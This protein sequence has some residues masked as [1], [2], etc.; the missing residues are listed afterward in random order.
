MQAA[1]LSCQFYRENQ[2]RMLIR[3]GN[4]KPECCV[5][6]PAEDILG[7]T[8]GVGQAEQA[9]LH[10]DGAGRYPAG[11]LTL[12]P[13]LLLQL[14]NL[15]VRVQPSMHLCRQPLSCGALWVFHQ[16]G[17]L[18]TKALL[19]FNQ[20]LVGSDASSDS[21]QLQLEAQVNMLSKEAVCRM[22]GWHL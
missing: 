21:Q 11:S 22:T 17:Q 5:Q 7:D 3:E 1:S 12:M 8:A 19:L 18:Q 9:Q 2:Y 15:L 14:L 16:G 13:C 4:S 20:T 6:A 10:A